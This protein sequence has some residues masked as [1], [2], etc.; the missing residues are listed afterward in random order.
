MNYKINI[1]V[2]EPNKHFE[3]LVLL[4]NNYYNLHKAYLYSKNIL[5][6]RWKKAE[7]YIKH[8][9][10]LA[11]LYAKNVIGGPW[12]EAEKSILNSNGYQ[13][14]KYVL[15][16]RWNDFENKM[17]KDNMNLFY[18]SEFFYKY[19]RYVMKER[20]IELE[21]KINKIIENLSTRYIYIGGLVDYSVK[22][23]K[24]RWEQIEHLIS[25]SYLGNIKKYVTILNNEELKDFE[26][27]LAFQTLSDNYES[28]SAKQYFK[29]KND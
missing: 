24:S 14:S 29:V 25:I 9:G 22:V 1:Y 11:Y 26:K 7:K 8:D 13:Y 10:R 17:I 12:K 23:K 28:V 4:D 18:F 21:E 6:S 27:K 15:K 19:S 20:W 16:S 3:D 2:N 5:K